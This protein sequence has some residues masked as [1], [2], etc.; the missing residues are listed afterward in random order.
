MKLRF[1]LMVTIGWLLACSGGGSGRGGIEWVR[2]PGK[3]YQMSRSEVTVG[4]Y[5]ACV[6]A[7]PCTEPTTC[8][9]GDPNW[10]ESGR[11]NHPVNCVSWDMANTFAKWAGGRLPTEDEWEYAAKGGEDYEYS[12]S[13]NVDEVAWYDGNSGGGTNEVCTKKPNSYGL[14]DMSG[15]VWE[16]TATAEGSYRVGR[17]G[18]CYSYPRFARVALRDGNAPSNR[19][20]NLGLRLSRSIP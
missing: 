16:W 1:V 10:N 19:N 13:S 2:I 11:E 17:G 7:G 15:N 8:D 9:W 14:C 20:N 5:R 3:S 18:S 4:Q 12:G 6:E